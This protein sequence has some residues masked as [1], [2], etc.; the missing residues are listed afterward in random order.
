MISFREIFIFEGSNPGLLIWR[1]P[2]LHIITHALNEAV[3]VKHLWLN[4][5][6]IFWDLS[7][8]GP[9]IKAYQ[10]HFQLSEK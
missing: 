4:T 1:A 2:G 10:S 6:A 9:V 3:Y 7:S 8:I 5:N